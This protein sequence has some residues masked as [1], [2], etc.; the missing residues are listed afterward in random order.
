MTS[1]LHGKAVSVQLAIPPASQTTLAQTSQ[2]VIDEAAHS[3]SSSSDGSAGQLR[4]GTTDAK[5]EA[6]AN[7]TVRD[8]HADTTA[9]G[10]T[11]IGRCVAPATET[12][13][14]HD[15]SAAAGADGNGS[16]PDVDKAEHHG[17]VLPFTAVTLTFRD[18]H[19]YVPTE[20]RLQS[21]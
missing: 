20:V 16:A 10:S 7:G 17:M 19:Y 1:F 3:S 15:C 12:V 9:N 4:N 13:A 21:W 2:Q 6:A 14:L 8:R 5:L 11:H 18:V